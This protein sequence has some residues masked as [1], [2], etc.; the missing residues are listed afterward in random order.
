M[1]DAVKKKPYETESYFKIKDILAEMGA[2]FRSMEKRGDFHYKGWIINGDGIGVGWIIFER[3]CYSSL[4]FHRSVYEFNK[5]ELELR[6]ENMQLKSDLEYREK[7]HLMA[8]DKLMEL[9]NRVLELV[10]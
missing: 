6:I 2:S 10:S 7:E 4:R 9:K 8:H 1:S 3:G 5:K